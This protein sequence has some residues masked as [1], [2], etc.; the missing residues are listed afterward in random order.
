MEV[1]WDELG[2]KFKELLEMGRP[3]VVASVIAASQRLHSHEQ[4]VFPS[5]T[6]IHCLLFLMLIVAH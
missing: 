2:S 5:N 3:G 4:K 1:I 6:F